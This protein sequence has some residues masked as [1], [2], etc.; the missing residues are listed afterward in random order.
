[1]SSPRVKSSPSPSRAQR[2]EPAP[3]SPVAAPTPEPRVLAIRNA[4]PCD[5]FELPV[6]P[7]DLSTLPVLS[8]SS[9]ER[10]ST[11]A[12]TNTT[13]ALGQAAARSPSHE[14]LVAFAES[15]R[16]LPPSEFR[17]VVERLRESRHFG[18]LCEA[19]K[20]D[21]SARSAFLEAGVKSGFLS[22]TPPRIAE[23]RGALAPPA[24]PSLVRNERALPFELRSVI[25]EENL[26]RASRYTAAFD[27]Y[28]DAWCARARNAETPHD[29][30]A[31]GPPSA[32]P[33][34]NEPGIEHSDKKDFGW[35]FGLTEEA[36]GSQRA[37]KTLSD[38]VSDLRGEP[39]AGSYGPSIDV[40]IKT[41]PHK[42]SGLKVTTEAAVEIRS[43]ATG[44]ETKAKS[45]ASL[46]IGP[47][48]LSLKRSLDSKGTEAVS[49]STKSD[50]FSG[51]IEVSVDKKGKAKTTLELDLG[52]GITSTTSVDNHGNFGFGAKVKKELAGIEFSAKVALNG[53]AIP[54]E[55]Y[56]D[57][58]GAQ[59]GIFGPMPELEAKVPWTSLTKDRRDW[60]AR[61]GFNAANWGTP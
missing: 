57:I 29:L 4:P 37:L 52:T 19:I 42:V 13:V 23:Q 26:A 43:S 25:H 27:T 40:G 10:N 1:M 16:S 18:P 8:P 2:S 47:E 3:R 22:V 28:L 51:A 35:N 59:P 5:A 46:Q 55:Y 48:L 21:A 49:L 54:P 20:H 61:Q 30:R 31:L 45:K 56:Q 24:Q 58:G 36:R 41:T 38:K 50:A 34:L 7:L 39:R 9:Q 15:M 33:A 14:T 53:Y 12:L 17:E 60:Y 11:R 6:K 32:P 44:L